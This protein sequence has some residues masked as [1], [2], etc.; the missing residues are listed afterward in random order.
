M[1]REVYEHPTGKPLSKE[2]L[3]KA[4]SYAQ[5]DYDL[6]S[7]APHLAGDT[8]LARYDDIGDGPVPEMADESNYYPD[9]IRW[10][11][12]HPD[13]RTNTSWKHPTTNSRRSRRT[14]QNELRHHHIEGLR[15]RTRRRTP[16]HERLLQG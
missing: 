6:W 14:R 13:V 15:P 9:V 7:H 11:L 5:R 3:A 2:W 10:L 8:G 12:A 1:I 16:P 4:Y